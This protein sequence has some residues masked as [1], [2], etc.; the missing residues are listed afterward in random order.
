MTDEYL[1][2]RDE[3]LEKAWLEEEP[4][5]FDHPDTYD[6]ISA[7]MDWAYEWCQE[8]INTLRVTIKNVD[9]KKPYLRREPNKT[10]SRTSFFLM[11]QHHV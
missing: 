10:Q 9:M 2:A 5:G 8:T 4:F 3:A 6:F 7:R 1:K 11:C